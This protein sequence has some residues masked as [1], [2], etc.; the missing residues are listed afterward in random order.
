MFLQELTNMVASCEREIPDYVARGLN[1]QLM[2][3]DRVLGGCERLLT[4]PIPVS[5]TRHT[6]RSLIFFLIGAYVLARLLACSHT[7]VGP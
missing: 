2:E 5:Y 7:N 6:T 3:M 1:D 4:T